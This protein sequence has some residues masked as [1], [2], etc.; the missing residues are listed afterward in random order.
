ME[1]VTRGFAAT[2]ARFPPLSARLASAL[3]ARPASQPASQP[4]VTQPSPVGRVA[5]PV[6]RL[7][8]SSSPTVPAAVP[9]LARVLLPLLLSPSRFFSSLFLL[10]LLDV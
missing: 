10:S 1:R 3:L 6:G 5:R 8:F 9:T 4:P 7:A 2:L